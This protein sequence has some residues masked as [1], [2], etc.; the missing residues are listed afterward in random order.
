MN[1][2]SLSL[3]IGVILFSSCSDL[4]TTD[5]GPAGGIGFAIATRETSAIS[6]KTGRHVAAM[7]GRVGG[8]RVYLHTLAAPAAGRPKV[9]SRGTAVTSSSFYDAMDVVAFDT[10]SSAAVFTAPFEVTKA[11]GWYS[12]K[13]W[14]KSA[15]NPVA[16]YAYAPA[17]LSSSVL[18]TAN[19]TTTAKEF[20]FTYHTPSTASAQQD[21]LGTR[22]ATFPSTDRPSQVPLTFS[23]LLTGVRF[24]VDDVKKG[25]TINKVTL[26]NVY[27]VA[28]YHFRTGTWDSYTTTGTV[29]NTVDLVIKDKNTFIETGSNY[30]MLLPQTL[31]STARVV[32]DYTDTDGKTGQLEASIGGQTWTAGTIC[33]YK[34]STSSINWSYDLTVTPSVEFSFAGG[35]SSVTIQSTK[36]SLGTT[37]T[38]AVQPWKVAGYITEGTYQTTAPSWLSLTD[39]S[40]DQG[41]TTTLSVSMQSYVQDTQTHHERM[42]GAWNVFPYGGT[43][44]YKSLVAALKASRYSDAA[45][46]GDLS[47]RD[48]Y[49]NITNVRNTANC[50]VI[51]KGGWYAIPMVFGNAIRGGKTNHVAFNPTVSTDQVL[52][53]FYDSQGLA[54]TQPWITKTDYFKSV[55]SAQSNTRLASIL[56]TDVNDDEMVKQSNVITTFNATD[57]TGYILFYVDPAHIYPGNFVIA[58]HSSTAADAPILW[59]WHIWVTDEDLSP[60]TVTNRSGV[61]YKMMPVNLGYVDYNEKSYSYPQ[62][63]AT[64]VFQ[65][66]ESGK[67]ATMTVTSH[68]GFWQNGGNTYYQWGRKDPFDIRNTPV[69]KGPEGNVKFTAQEFKLVS[70]FDGQGKA[71]TAVGATI[72]H[73]TWMLVNTKNPKDN[74]WLP[75]DR[76]NLWDANQTSDG[77]SDA[78]VTPTIYDPCPYP[79]HVPATN[80]YSGFINT[81]AGNS[82][83][84][85]DANAVGGWL[86]IGF[87]FLTEPNTMT[88]T[89]NVIFFPATGY[90]GETDGMLYDWGVAGSYWTAGY[91]SISE[92]RA[93][94]LWFYYANNGSNK[95]FYILSNDNRQAAPWVAR[96]IRPVT[97][98]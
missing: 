86:S 63:S 28:T 40:G 23:H 8:R 71:A 84:F 41:L 75:K 7:R 54:I 89:G 32:L 88:Q 14:P 64:I 80:A 20:A 10:V 92:S 6:A 74:H 82:S 67:T 50:Y 66:P 53:D 56:W 72:L 58:L 52:A 30:F 90:R 44:E 27:T 37:A 94:S 62:R 83:D 21:L 59:S 97:D 35:S 93:G 91:R 17:N 69:F 42:Q 26:E 24:A 39:V 48:A 43:S 61:G 15:T 45:T 33:T 55:L 3:I 96:S 19:T 49:G 11:S 13:S 1:R 46:L 85:N 57:S 9:L 79:F 77:A 81:D 65:Q 31:P 29:T 4:L 5:D 16:F 25:I 12:G 18:T 68:V 98:Q 95:D 70:G 47:L 34:V 51:H 78:T 76:L 38:T 60:V 87:N 36:T 2:L 73:P 22:S